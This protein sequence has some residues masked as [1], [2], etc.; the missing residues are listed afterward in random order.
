MA[1][2]F[3]VIASSAAGFRNLGFEDPRKRKGS[4]FG[5]DAIVAQFIYCFAAGGASLADAEGWRRIPWRGVWR[6]WIALPMNRP[7][8]NGCGRKHPRVSARSGSC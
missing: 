4:G 8:V 6:A 5:P 1:F 7:W 3:Q 2:C